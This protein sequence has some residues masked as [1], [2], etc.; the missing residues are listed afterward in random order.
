MFRK[1]EFWCNSLVMTMAYNLSWLWSA[2]NKCWSSWL[3]RIVRVVRITW[4]LW[5]FI[6]MA[7]VWQFGEAIP[8]IPL[9][10]ASLSWESKT[11]LSTSLVVWLSLLPVDVTTGESLSV[12][13]LPLS[14]THLVVAAGPEAWGWGIKHRTLSQKC[15]KTIF[16]DS[17]N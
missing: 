16:F 13:P 17:T 10:Y 11:V 1:R 5:C 3:V 4:L 7:N 14:F 9:I 2:I 12:R 6:Q 15:K 8:I